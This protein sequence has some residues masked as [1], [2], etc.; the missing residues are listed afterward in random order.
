VSIASGE[1]LP[2]SLDEGLK[3]ISNKK[4]RPEVRA[5]LLLEKAMSIYTT[6]QL[7][8]YAAEVSM[9]REPSVD[10][11]VNYQGVLSLLQ[12]LL[13]DSFDSIDAKSSEN[14]NLFASEATGLMDR[15]S[16]EAF[17]NLMIRDENDRAS[18]EGARHRLMFEGKDVSTGQLGSRYG[19]MLPSKSD[20]RVNSYLFGAGKFAAKN[21]SMLYCGGSEP[22]LAQLREYKQKHDVALSVEKF[23]W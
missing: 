10:Y 19:M 6:D 15:D 23:D 22:V 14:F 16:F 2:E 13:E 20:S 5:K 4:T 1:G 3:H 12:E 8:S 9:D 17:L 21:W 18:I 11:V 7:F